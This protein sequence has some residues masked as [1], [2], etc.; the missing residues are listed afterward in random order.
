MET[1]GD[2]HH[3]LREER[4]RQVRLPGARYTNT[5]TPVCGNQ[6]GSNSMGKSEMLTV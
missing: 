2:E 5:L 1:L 6:Y 4:E 3:Q